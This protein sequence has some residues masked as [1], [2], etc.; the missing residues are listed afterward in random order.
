MFKGNLKIDI[1]LFCL[2]FYYNYTK[3][4]EKTLLHSAHPSALVVLLLQL[5]MVREGGEMQHNVFQ[6]HYFN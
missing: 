2:H 3:T 4:T 1:N 5:Q 6:F